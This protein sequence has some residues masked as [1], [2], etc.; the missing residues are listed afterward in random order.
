[1]TEERANRVR[2]LFDQAADLPPESRGALLD[3]TCRNEPELRARV[4]YLLAC[5]DRLRTQETGVFASPVLRWTEDTTRSPENGPAPEA[6]PTQLGR[7]AVVEE[8]GRGG[9]GCVLR[10]YDP[11]L[12]RDLAIKV[13]LEAHRHDPV[14]VGR[15]TEEAQIGGQLQHPGIVPVYEVGRAEERPYFTMKLVRGHTLAELLRER[16]DPHEGLPRFLQVFE[17]VCQTIAYAHSRGVIHRDLKPSNVMV[18]A[19]GEVQ[20]MDW[21]IAK[22]LVREGGSPPRTEEEEPR[23]H[24]EPEGLRTGRSTGQGLVS[25]TG[26]VLGTPSYMPPEQARGAR[27]ELDERCDVFGLGGILCEILTN[28]P[29]YSGTSDIE[30]LTK[31]A[32]G[33]LSEALTRLEGCGADAELIRL[34]RTS[35]A[36]DPAQR[37]RDAGVLAK[38]MAAHRES[39]ERRLHEAELAEVAARSRAEEERTRRRLT[40]GLALSVLV[41]VLVAGGGWLWIDR[42]RSETERQTRALRTEQVRDAEAALVQAA[43]LRQQARADGLSG[44]WAEARAQVRRAEALLERWPDEVELGGRVRALLSELD[45]EAADR[46]LLVRLDEIGL[47]RTEMRAGEKVFDDRPAMAEYESAL[48]GYGVA[49]GTPVGQAAARIR[50]RPAP[51]RERVVAALEDWLV[52]LLKYRKSEEAKWLTGVLAEADS[53]PWR[54]KLRVARTQKQRTELEQLAG[55]PRLLDQPPQSL[56]MLSVALDVRGAGQQAQVVLRRARERYPNDY[57][58]THELG[59]RDLQQSERPIEAV[60]LFMVCTA[61]RPES[62][63]PYINLGSALV[64]VGELEEGIAAYRRALTLPPETALAHANLGHALFQK[65]DTAGAIAAW[66]RALELRPNDPDYHNDIGA[67][68]V[69]RGD[70]D[71]A[72]ESYRKAVALKPDNELPATNLGAILQRQGRFREAVTVYQ[73]FLKS[74]SGRGREAVEAALRETER[75]IELD[76]QLD[77]F[78]KGIRKPAGPTQELELA[79]LCRVRKLYGAATDFYTRAFAAPGLAENPDTGYR[80]LAACCAVQTADGLGADAAVLDESARAQLRRQALKWLEAEYEA[81]AVRYDVARG[82]E[83]NRRGGALRDWQLE[84]QLSGVRDLTARERFPAAERARWQSLWAGVEE[85]ASGQRPAPLARGRAYAARRQW[86]EAA[87]CYQLVAEQGGDDGHFWFEHA[88]LLLLS[89]D[90]PGYA[91]VCGRLVDWWGKVPGMRAYHVARACTLAPDAGK[92]VT[93]AGGLADEDL[94]GSAAHWAL[95]ERAAI[96]YR[97]GHFAEAVP[98]LEQSLKADTRPGTRVVGWLWLALAN[99]RLGKTEEAQRWADE[100]R[101]WLNDRADGMPANSDRDLGLDLHNWLEAH[102]L[103]REVEAVLRKAGKP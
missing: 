56:L 42:S 40:V 3:A 32:R 25:R 81:L 91:T 90:R 23:P 72:V 12:G 62:P 70:L 19:F 84:P 16:T 52:I 45:D 29:P 69:R 98:L 80:F 60:R 63:G 103:L 24:D 43:S 58:I 61:L 2:V 46:Q 55:D 35:L 53:D 1:M 83:K 50:Q 22:V 44:K 78:L 37:P 68:L 93:R 36:P 82:A 14:R 11:D 21:G 89:G 64:R 4:E 66:R 9:M 101:R 27:D 59:M 48:R 102:I 31:A 85:L 8:I 87:R 34:A 26:S 97:T 88:A 18:G 75:A 51:V 47:L 79:E 38:E 13:L 67:A 20:V 7:Y 17:Q 92:N 94:K 57:W 71:G 77:D 95:T 33:D 5:N 10:G 99:Q 49:F 28:K 96:L 6:P 76:G 54:Q 86:I 30:V 74:P 73:E 15:F 39:M 41:T 100:A 65:G